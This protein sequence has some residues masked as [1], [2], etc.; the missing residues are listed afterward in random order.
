MLSRSTDAI[1]GVYILT[2]NLTEQKEINI[3]KPGLALF[4]KGY[5]LYIGSAV[6]PGGIDGRLKHHLR[7]SGKPHWHIDYLRKEASVAEVF[8]LQGEKELEHKVA[9]KLMKIFSIPV[10]KF[11]SS[12]CNCSS[13]LFYSKQKPSVEEL[14][15]ILKEPRLQIWVK[16]INTLWKSM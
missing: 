9:D 16:N 5:Y 8:C 3:G 14:K 2:L 10:N 7:I 1:K 13:H 4:K 11:G 15:L 6:G 12:D